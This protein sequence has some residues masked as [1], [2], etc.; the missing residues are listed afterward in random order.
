MHKYCAVCPL[1]GPFG[2]AEPDW[3]GS[4]TT[5]LLDRPHGARCLLGESV[6]PVAD[7]GARRLGASRPRDRRTPERVPERVA[8]SHQ[9]QRIPRD[10]HLREA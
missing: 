10:R 9:C 3:T 8:L 4:A 2:W 1:T 5:G 7:H 6:V